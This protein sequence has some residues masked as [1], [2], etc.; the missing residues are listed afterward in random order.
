MNRIL[1]ALVLLA[2]SVPAASVAQRRG[3]SRQVRIDRDH[4]QWNVPYDGR[5]TF[6]RIRYDEGFAGRFSRGQ[7]GW[8]HDWPTAERHF[9][10]ILHELTNMGPVMDASN[11][12]TFEDP[13]LSRYPVAYLSEPGYWNMNDEEIAGMRNYL[14]KGGFLIVDDFRDNEWYNFEAQ[15]RLALPEA[16]LVQLDASHPIFDSFF[17]IPSLEGFQ[18]PNFRVKPLFYGVFEDNDPEKRLMVIVNYNNDIGDYWEWSD[19]GWLPI[20]LSNDAYKLGVN[21]V[22]YAMMR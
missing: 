10:K 21:Y 8:A 9:T 4:K 12:L 14:L 5:F 6:V 3:R 2:M 13:E 19:S 18:N 20:D 7:P 1:I 15:M 17:R 11:I 16:R 22:I